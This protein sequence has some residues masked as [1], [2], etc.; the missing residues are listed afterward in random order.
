ME[1]NMLSTVKIIKRGVLSIA[2][3]AALSAPATAG[4]R[5]N[6]EHAPATS[7]SA[8]SPSVPLPANSSPASGFQWDDAAIGAAGMLGLMGLVGASSQAARRRRPT[9]V[10]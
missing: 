3:I 6:Y 9:A 5:V 10:S 8:E 7:A 4:A 1:A 2:V